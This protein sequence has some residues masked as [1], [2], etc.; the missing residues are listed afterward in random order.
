MRYQLY[1]VQKQE[2][3]SDTGGLTTDHDD[4]YSTDDRAVIAA[5]QGNY[6]KKLDRN[7]TVVHVMEAGE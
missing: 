6:G 5:L 7:F 3:L 1:D 4:A 2:Y